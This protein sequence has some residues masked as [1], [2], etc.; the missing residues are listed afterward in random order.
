MCPSN[1]RLRTVLLCHQ[2]DPLSPVL[3]TAFEAHFDWLVELAPEPDPEART[4]A[5]WRLRQRPDRLEAGQTIYAEAIAPHR[6]FYL[7][8]LAPRRLSGGRGLVYPVA[9]GGVLGCQQVAGNSCCVEIAWSRSV[10]QI[11][12]SANGKMTCLERTRSKST[13][14]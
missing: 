8:L 1:P 5:T 11:A 12:I 2:P 3:A 14:L 10:R 7:D 9:R 6:A 4:V 13:S